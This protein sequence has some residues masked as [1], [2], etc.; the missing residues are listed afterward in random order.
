[1]ATPTQTNPGSMAR[2]RPYKES[3]LHKLE[4]LLRQN[5]PHSEE[6]RL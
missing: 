1:M 6:G 3:D 5:F 2:I 4:E